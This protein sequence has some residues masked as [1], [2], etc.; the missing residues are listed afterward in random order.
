MG[1]FLKSRFLN[2]FS[3]LGLGCLFFLY[4][5]ALVSPYE[6]GDQFH[7][8]RLYIFL[9]NLPIGDVSAAG[10]T[11]V[12]AAEPISL[13][14]LWLGSNLG[15]DKDVYISI[16][17]SIFLFG[18]FLLCRRYRVGFLFFILLLTNFYVVVLMTGAE[19]LKF[20]FIFIVYSILL[21]KYQV[22]SRTL[23]FVSLFAHIQSIVVFISSFVYFKYKEFGLFLLTFRSN[24]RIIMIVFI[25]IG[26]GF[27]FYFQLSGQLVSKVS[28]YFGW[29]SSF[30]IF[31]ISILFSLA[32][33]ISRRRFGFILL[34]LLFI[35]LVLLFGGD[36]INMIAFFVVVFA[37]VDEGK[38]NN[39]LFLALMVYFTLKSVPFVGDIFDYGN[40]F[41]RAV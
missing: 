33:I 31:K 29:R 1:L 5:F 22:L 26:L 8:R 20:S 6:Y 4:S 32:I 12:G 19:R 30:D 16:W 24:L 15:V 11:F 23:L 28:F 37:L 21:N 27:F 25:L 34:W 40:G 14:L 39:V 41:F 17:N 18:L 3:Y 2:M 9:E 7:Y 10:K 38:T 35:P 36:R 13:Y